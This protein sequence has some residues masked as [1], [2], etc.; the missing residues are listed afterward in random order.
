LLM[1]KHNSLKVI[2]THCRMCSYHCGIDLHM[3]NNKIEKITGTAANRFSEGSLCI[4][5]FAAADLVYSPQR[6]LKPLKKTAS[7]WQ[8]IE[9]EIA[10]SEIAE[11]LSAVIN[12]YGPQSASVWKGEALGSEQLRDLAHRFAHALGTPNIFSNDTIC[13]VSKKTAIRS[14]LGAYPMPDIENAKSIFIWGANP[15]ASHYPL[16][17]KII[18]ARK[19]GLRVILIDP[20]ESTF[21]KYAD[22]LILIRP[23]SDGALALGMIN[24][25]IRSGSYDHTFV[26]S[27]TIGFSGLAEYA[28]DFTPGFVEKETGIKSADLKMLCEIITSS[29]PAS[30][31]MVGT[32]PEHHSNGYNNIRAIASLSALC[33]CIDRPG[34]ELMPDKAPLNSAYPTADLLVKEKPIGAEK[35]PVFFDYQKEG[36]TIDA[37]EAM[38]SG[39]PYPIKAMIMTGANPVLTNPNAEKV[40]KALTNLDL[41]VVKDLFMT[42][43]AKLADYILPAATFLERS[44]VIAYGT[45]Q[46]I[47]LTRKVL[48]FKDCQDEYTF[49]RSLALRLG[50]GDWFR[51]ANED[52]LN[53]WLLEPSG[54][55]PEELSI[56]PDG[57]SYK[58]YTYEKF[59][60]EGFKTASGKI[61][62]ISA[63]LQNYGYPE[64]PDYKQ[65]A[66]CSE[67]LS[68]NY[69]YVL[70]TGARKAA[71]NHSC[72]HNISRLQKTA[73]DPEL[74]IHPEDAVDLKIANG[75]CVEII[76]KTGS[77]IIKVVI[78]EPEAIVKGFVHIPHGYD[79]C[80]VN[81]ITLDDVLDPIS[82][83][84]A[85]K[86]VPVNIRKVKAPK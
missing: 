44:E 58:A 73:P 30:S 77:L 60:T 56:K 39:K 40:K 75:E 26:E 80:N 71:F 38:I 68:K 23:A 82:G 66:F 17:R 63:Y 2:S 83:F 7:G 27:Q 16:A 54:I 55:T 74:E 69:E 31:F 42:E 76:S 52:D 48:S 61:E 12:Q 11:K 70:I 72:Y 79:Q 28:A 81:E 84:P 22:H 49:F 21:S 53:R 13:A 29:A 9:L 33:G 64:L 67:L 34:G 6:L 19:K 10:L 24:Y 78:V 35:Y 14:V 4:K 57:Y 20:R 25:I 1:S 46:T 36:H 47:A 50:L 8:E 85:V 43:T 5:G 15:L 37:M 45:P 65:A 86:S 59:K 41:F 3:H 51:W 62:F 18:K 32:G